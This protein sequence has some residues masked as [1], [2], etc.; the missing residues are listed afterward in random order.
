MGCRLP[1]LGHFP[2]LPR[3]NIEAASPQLADMKNVAAASRFQWFQWMDGTFFDG[4]NRVSAGTFSAVVAGVAAV[5]LSL[6]TDP[7]LPGAASALPRMT[8]NPSLPVPTITIFE[9]DDCAS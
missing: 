1:A 2:A 3:R 6:G 8:G 9:F 7:S 5:V 4:F